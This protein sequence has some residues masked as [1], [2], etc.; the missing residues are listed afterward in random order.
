MSHMLRRIATVLAIALMTLTIGS[1]PAR[2]GGPTSILLSAHA[3]DRSRVVATGYDDAAYAQLNQLLQPVGGGDTSGAKH[4]TGQ[5]IQAA[6][7]IH[8]TQVWRVSTIYPDAPGG[9]WVATA[10]SHDGAPDL[11]AKP[12]WHRVTDGVALKKVLGS[13]GLLVGS[14]AA[15]PA[16]APGSADQVAGQPAAAPAELAAAGATGESASTGWR[17]AVPG[18]ALGA[19]LTLAVG[20]LWSRRRSVASVSPSS[21]EL[22]H[23]L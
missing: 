20:G 5:I 11:A 17:W 14:T 9:P 15:A 4:D 6:W 10:E 21:S 19:V 2:A 1:T 22:V 13:L 3:D 23:L 18:F 12:G 16:A 7:M 8:D